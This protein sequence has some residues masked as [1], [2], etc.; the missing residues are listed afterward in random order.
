MKKILFIIIACLYTCF[1]Y[2]SN[3]SK[4]YSFNI[5]KEIKAVDLKIPRNK[6][7]FIDPSGNR[8]IDAN[9]QC[10]LQFNV[11]NDGTID[12]INY[13]AKINITGKNK[14]LTHERFLSL[15]TIPKGKSISVTIPVQSNM[16][17]SPRV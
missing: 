16:Q 9:E 4:S 17:R 5:P 11:V 6:V 13:L 15:P 14:G 3:I 1:A 12:A 8:A 7:K 10:E 2:S